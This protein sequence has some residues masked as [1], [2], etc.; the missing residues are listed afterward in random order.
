MSKPLFTKMFVFGLAL[1]SVIGGV[2]EAAAQDVIQASGGTIISIDTVIDGVFTSISG[3]TIRETSA[4]QL[5]NNGTIVLTLPSGFEWNSSLTGT[6]II[7]DI[8]PVGAQNTGLNVVFE[9]ISATEATFRVTSES[10]S[11]GAG[12]GPG[13]VTISG[14]ELIPTTTSVPN[15]GQITNTGST[16]PT[17]VNYGSLSTIPG[18]IEEVNVETVADGT[19]SIV[20]AQSLL[21]A[22]SL[23]VFAIARDAGGNFIENIALGGASDWR[24]INITGNLD[25]SNLTPAANLRSATFSSNLTGSANIE[26]FFS[27]AI[28]N[29]SGTITVLPREAS[30][31]VIQTQPSENAVA[32]VPFD[33]QPVIE[34]LDFFGNRATVDNSTNVSAAI[35][36]GGGSLL[37]T[38][39]STSVNGLV[40]F[41]DLALTAAGNITLEF[42]S[43]SLSSVISDPITVEAGAPSQ[44][45][46]LTLPQ[47]VTEGIIISPS[48]TVGL[49]DAFNN[50]APVSGISISLALESGSGTF[51]ASDQLTNAAGVAAF[52][53]AVFATQGTKTIRASA[54][55]GS[56][57]DQI[58]G[59]ITVLGDDQ[60]SNFLIEATDGSAIGTQTAG[61]P[62]DVRI[63]AVNGSGTTITDFTGTVDITSTS[64]IASGGGT[65][66]AFTAGVLAAHTVSLTTSGEHTLTATITGET[67]SGTSELFTVNPAGVDFASSEV[68]ANPERIVA[69]GTSTSDL[70]V[71]LRDE[72]GNQVNSGGETIELTTTSGQ[73]SNQN[74]AGESSLFADDNSDGTYSATLTSADSIDVA[75]ITALENSTAFATTDVEFVSG[76][77]NAF[78]ITLPENAGAPAVQTAGMPFNISVEAVDIS[79]N[80]IVSFSGNLQFTSEADISSGETAVINNGFLENHPVTI[81]ST[82]DDITL[83]VTDPS[84]FGISGTS[85]PFVVVANDPEPSLSQVSVNPAVIKNNGVDQST[86][87]VILRDQFLNQVFADYTSSI[88]LSSIQI[89]ENGIPTG[90][91]PDA[92]LGAL[93]FFPLSGEYKA[94]LSS[95]TTREVVEISADYNGTALPQNPQV[96]IVAPNTWQPSGAPN[97]RNDWTRTEN[98]SL[99]TVPGPTDFVIIPGGAADY[100]DLDL[101]VSIGSIEIESGGELVLFGGNS[102]DISGSAEVNGIFDIEDDTFLDIRGDFTGTGSFSTGVSVEIDLGGDVTIDSFLARTNDSIIRLNGESQQVVNSPNILAQRL[103]VLNNVLVT[104]G[105]LIDSNDIFISDGNTL[106]L[107]TGAGITL[108]ATNTITG[109]GTLLLN[110]NTLVVRGNFDL[111]RVDASEGTVIF[112]IRLDE[113]FVDFPDLEQQ[114][115]ANLSEMKNVIINNINGVRTFQ[116]ILVDGTLVLENGELI[117]A[118][119]SNFIAPDITYNNGSLTFQRTISQPGWRLMSSPITSTFDDLFGEL[120]VQGIGGTTFIDRQPNILWYDESVEG[121]DNQRW[122]APANVADNLETGRGYFFYVFGDVPGDSDYNDNLPTTLSVNGQENIPAAADF[123][124][125]VTYTAAA[126]TGWNIVGNPFGATLNWDDAGWTKE[127]IDNVIYVWDRASNQYRYWNGVAGN[128]GN[129][130]IAPFQ[131]FWVKANAEDPELSVQTGAKTTGGIFRKE[132]RYEQIPVIALELETEFHSTS[133]HFS[134]TENGSFATDSQDAYRLLPFEADTYLEIYSLFEDGTE[135]AVNNLPRDFGKTIEIPVQVGALQD[136]T[137]YNGLVTMTWSEFENIPES[138]TVELQDNHTGNRINLRETTFYDFEVSGQGKSLYAMNTVENFRL[139]AKAKSNSSNPRFSLLITP[140]SDGSEFPEEVMLDQNF[141]N[142][143]N[144]VTSIR[145]GLP[146][147]DRVRIDV[148]DVLGRKVLTLT[149]QRYQAGFHSVQFDGRS[150]SSGVYLYRLITSDRVMNKKMTFIK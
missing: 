91:T 89:S 45:Q 57:A 146:A 80:R 134:F 95:T 94:D 145:F 139:L 129:G 141:P 111:N 140:G 100:P 85:V 14:L 56:I 70:T 138:W 87:T 135:L 122:R 74:V 147:E 13:R 121:T 112:G 46:F 71:T 55:G 137:F 109:E 60:V 113:N 83:S 28:L 93:T 41:G 65:T 96:S 6:N 127:N 78:L 58:S 123:T 52:D 36:S 105:D 63:T 103:E 115:I 118:S 119:G 2:R 47:N 19:G 39:T 15:T 49:Y 132:N 81:T 142:P 61:V 48:I 66:A 150:L 22:E 133:T 125:P 34:L 17:G 124:F 144:P 72:F 7:V 130:L 40:S 43:G 25:Q 44:M 53:D 54:A 76:E 67:V 42:S 31:M 86:V 84:L 77:I 126:D 69:N 16:G 114:Q 68:T 143:F 106:E 35:L 26:A 90:G 20:S 30:Q 50:P 149:D 131:A 104:T 59:D 33:R 37:G 8:A 62:F 148:Y 75:T 101:N 73:L 27:G 3:P 9:S 99:G 21:A 107:Q 11:R 136:A 18:S 51:T 4:G 5:S 1:L 120:T 98:W 64:S 116:D 24:L 88:S 92:T 12:Q 117:I 108:D 32:G 29:P 102:I 97:Q 38:L 82:G 10:R 23:E 128:L 79:G 110:D